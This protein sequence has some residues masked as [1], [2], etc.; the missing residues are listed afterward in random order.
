MN[1]DM[2]GKGLPDPE[3][4]K[5]LPSQPRKGVPNTAWKLVLLLRGFELL[6]EEGHLRNSLR[7]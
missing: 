5:L 1:H 6:A 7:H 2:L 4:D 3:T